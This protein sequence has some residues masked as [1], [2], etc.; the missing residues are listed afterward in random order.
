MRPDDNSILPAQIDP[1]PVQARI[2]SL[3]S[4]IAEYGLVCVVVL[5][6]AGL[7]ISRAVF[8]TPPNPVLY[9]VIAGC[10]TIYAM[11]RVGMILPQMRALTMQRDARANLR[12]S[13]E[14]ICGRGYVF[15][16]DVRDARGQGI[17]AVLA[18]PG[19]VFSLTFRHMQHGS[20][21]LEAVDYIPPDGIQVNGRQ[22]LADPA[23]HARHAANALYQMLGKAGLDTLA[24]QPVLIF[25]GW[26][27]GKLPPPEE[28][29]IWVVNE[30]LLSEEVL[31]QR[32]TVEP[33][34]LIPL[35]EMLEQQTRRVRADT[36]PVRLQ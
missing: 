10:F 22:V 34:H 13:I 18:G 2:A 36:M 19:G 29:E 1:G 4:T 33:K 21:A 6:I 24:V 20:D 5:T 26:K 32:H 28:R 7:E 9:G 15:F 12:R 16:D 35:A 31:R 17:G 30:T 23:G 3:K 8:N 27:I 14:S 11:V 25:P